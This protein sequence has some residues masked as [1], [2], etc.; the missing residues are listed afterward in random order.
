VTEHPE[1]EIVAIWD[2]NPDRGAAATEQ[3]GVPSETDLEVVL[4][5]DDVD[6]V[7]INAY[8]SQHP[9]VIKT[10]LNYGKHVFTE[11]ALTIKTK[12][13]DEIVNMVNES[14]VKFMISLP[15]RTRSEKLFMKQVLD[16]G[17][18]GDITMMRSRIA[19]SA[20]LEVWF[21]EEKHNAWFGDAEL[22]GGGALF[23][24]GCHTVDVMR[25]FMG[26]PKSVVAKINT[27]TD[28]YPIDDNSVIVIEFE[29]K[30]LGIL[31]TAWVQQRTSPKPMEIYGTKGHVTYDGLGD[32]VLRSTE[33]EAEG[34]QGYIKPTN[35]PDA[36]PTPFQQWVS[37]ILHDT[38]MTITVEDGRN[39]TE[40]LERSYQAARE[41]REVTF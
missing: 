16:A 11:K 1:A 26:K 14:G 8:T 15:H 5:R 36:L 22:A 13:A 23:D 30:A 25:W 7:V 9:W 29:N 34:V 24:L 38:E 37:A 32:L 35:L 41:G 20:A 19:H 4:S 17:W 10:A 31:D 3:W 21:T 12:D 18:L 2:D 6:A 27:F 39:L 33:L 40:M 28:T